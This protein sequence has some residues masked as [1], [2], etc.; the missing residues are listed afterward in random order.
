MMKNAYSEIEKLQTNLATIRKAGGWSAEEF[1]KMIGVSRQTI[2]N[3]ENAAGTKMTPTQYIAIRTVLDYEIAEHPD[4]KVL[5]RTVNV[6]LNS[7]ELSE[8]LSESDAKVAKAFVE[9]A[10]QN[11]LDEDAIK[12][13]MVALLGAVAAGAAVGTLLAKPTSK[14]LS[15][16]MKS[17]K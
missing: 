6:C 9:G 14:W 15:K 16:F 3:L 11:G 12:D 2:W 17:L 1:G 7:D 8:S 4:N 10:T 13:G 5:A